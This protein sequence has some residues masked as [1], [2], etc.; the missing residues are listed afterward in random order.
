MT[1]FA[2]ILALL[3]LALGLGAGSAMQQSLAIAIIS[4]LTL[5]MPVLLVVLPV[6]LSLHRRRQLPT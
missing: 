5:Q 2:A 1:T 3:P 6:L 4:G